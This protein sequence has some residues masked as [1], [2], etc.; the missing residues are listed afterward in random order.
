MESMAE[1]AT[2]VH[3]KW[4][5]LAVLVSL[6][7]AVVIQGA[8]LPCLCYEGTIKIRIA[9]GVDALIL[10]RVLVAWIRKERGKGWIFYAALPFVMI[11][12]IELAVYLQHLH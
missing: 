3:G 2:K 12:V 6:L 1:A 10:I 5:Y 9:L 4:N 11:L 8:V 7:A